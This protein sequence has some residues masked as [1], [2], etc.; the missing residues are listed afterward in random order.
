MMLKL[1]P[2]KFSKEFVE[3]LTFLNSFIFVIPSFILSFGEFMG[4]GQNLSFEN[5]TFS[6]PFPKFFYVNNDCKFILSFF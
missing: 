6:R 2:V 4:G 3:N 1:L 5:P